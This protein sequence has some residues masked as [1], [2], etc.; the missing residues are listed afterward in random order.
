MPA[1]AN[2]LC[3]SNNLFSEC[4]EPY[5]Q[6]KKEADNPETL[7]RSRYCAFALRDYSYI[8]KTWHP[9]HLPELSE[10]E[11]NSFV[12]LEIVKSSFEEDEGEVEFIAKL[13]FNNRLETIHEISDFE[14]IDGKWL[15]LSGEFLN[16]NEK[17]RKI[18][19]S[20]DCPCG[21]GKKFKHCHFK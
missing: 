5:L 2:C 13:I 9:E 17:P 20:E 18:S 14:K 3:G 11:P 12:S 1:E 15:Y 8:R 21:S 7:M 19:K 16:D 6:N 4:C 10:D